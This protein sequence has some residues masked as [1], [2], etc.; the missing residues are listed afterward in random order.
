MNVSHIYQYVK[1]ITILY[2]GTSLPVLQ[3]PKSTGF[4][5]KGSLPQ[6][7]LQSTLQSEGSRLAS[8]SFWNM[9]MLMDRQTD[10]QE[11]EVLPPVQKT[12]PR[13]NVKTNGLH[14]N[15][16]DQLS[17]SMN[18][19][20]SSLKL[21]VNPAIMRHRRTTSLSISLRKSSSFDLSYLTYSKHFTNN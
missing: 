10:C 21:P 7:N 15:E 11:Q 13:F 9:K 8:K 4:P 17:L 19:R 20:R 14:Q 1:F 3:V 5:R 2:P 16:H 12:S 6:I 18:E